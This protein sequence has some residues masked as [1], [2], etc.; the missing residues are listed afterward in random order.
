MDV[1]LMPSQHFGPPGTAMSPFDTRHM[2]NALPDFAQQRYIQPL[3]QAQIT[4][5]SVMDP[6]I[7]YSPYSHQQFAGHSSGQHPPQHLQQLHLQL[8]RGYSGYS[9]NIQSSPS[10]LQSHSQTYLPQQQMGHMNR[11]RQPQYPT[12]AGQQR[13]YGQMPATRL[14]SGMDNGHQMPR[15]QVESPYVS[16]GNPLNSQQPP[17]TVFRILS[18]Q[19]C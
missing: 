16:S 11:P 2:S 19:S 15:L 3:S 4:Q 12:F 18:L 8:Q 7:A 1:A 10:D 14:Q 5:A 9:M 17:G 13:R 6:N